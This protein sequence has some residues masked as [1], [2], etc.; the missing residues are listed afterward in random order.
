MPRRG[1]RSVRE[2]ASSRL[3]RRTPIV[4]YPRRGSREHG[5]RGGPLAATTAGGVPARRRERARAAPP[6]RL[7]RDPPRADGPAVRG[8]R[9]P[10]VAPPPP[11]PGGSCRARGVPCRPGRSAADAT[12]R[13]LA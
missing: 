12:P 11:P 10:V 2:G 9:D 5:G 6:G 3:P 7:D 1:N 4:V 8:D 13:R